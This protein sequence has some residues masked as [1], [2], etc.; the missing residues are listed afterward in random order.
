VPERFLIA[1]ARDALERGVAPPER[2]AKSFYN[3]LLG[4]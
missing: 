4:R 1:A 3:A 2:I